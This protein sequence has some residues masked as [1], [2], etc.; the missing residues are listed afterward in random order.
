MSNQKEIDALLDDSWG[1]DSESKDTR[2]SS[3]TPQGKDPKNNIAEESY[4]Y[5]NEEFDDYDESRRTESFA[6]SQS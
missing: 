3:L 1:M 2:K 4:S 6:Q 5:G